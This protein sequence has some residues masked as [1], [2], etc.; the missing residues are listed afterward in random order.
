MSFDLFSFAAQYSGRIQVDKVGF[1]RKNF[2]KTE[3]VEEVFQNCAQ[4]FRNP[5]VFMQKFSSNGT[6]NEDEL[7][8]TTLGTDFFIQNTSI[9]QMRVAFENGFDKLAWRSASQLHQE[10]TSNKSV[11]DRERFNALM[12]ASFVS[13][14]YEASSSSVNVP[15]LRD[16]EAILLNASEAVAAAAK[17]LSASLSGS[18]G[19]SNRF[20]PTSCDILRCKLLRALSYLA[21]KNMPLCARTLLNLPQPCLDVP[22][23]KINDFATIA[24]VVRYALL[25]SLATMNR[26]EI[27]RNVVENANFRE[28]LERDD[29]KTSKILLDSFYHCHWNVAW[30]TLT[31]ILNV[32]RYDMFLNKLVDK[33]RTSIQNKL[34]LQYCK[35]YERLSLNTMAESFGID[36]EFVHNRL[37]HLI[38]DG[39]LSARIDG[40]QHELVKYLPEARVDAFENTLSAGKTFENWTDRDVFYTNILDGG[41]LNSVP[42]FEFD[43]PP[44]AAMLQA[45]ARREGGHEHRKGG[46]EQHRKMA[47]FF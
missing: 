23:N 26:D 34:L 29:C 13:L 15:Q 28:W 18:D 2:P 37:L 12:E 3:G 32:A 6:I 20:Y 9:V 30:H 36:Q 10:M 43:K 24:D 21:N 25:C 14:I 19:D 41:F 7:T 17:N 11:S 27:R 8:R 42:S 1:I 33:M 40:V 16:C 4:R 5:S 47:V 35:P 39:A 22:D 44:M 38:D 45:A 31:E 46:H